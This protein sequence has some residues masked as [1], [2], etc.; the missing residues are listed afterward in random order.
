MS[1]ESRDE[2][3]HEYPKPLD[4]HWKENWYFNFID[5]EAGAWGIN[6]ISLMRLK[7]QGRFSAFHV[8][9]G[10]VLMYS[11]VIDIQD[12]LPDLTDGRLRFEFIEPFSKFRLTFDG[13]RHRVELDYTARFDVFDYAGARRPGGDKALAVNHYEQALFAKG[14]VEKSGKAYQIDCLGHRDHSWGFRNEAK[15]SGWN[16]MAVQFPDKTIN[17]SLVRIG[18]AFMGSGFISNSEGN[19]RINRVTIQDTKFKNKVPVSSVFT[20]HDKQ[21]GTWRLRSEKFSGLYLPM[22]EKGKGVVVHENFSDYTNLETD[23]KG[24]GI[25]EYLINPEI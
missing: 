2:L 6:H 3:V 4:S 17:M 13:P 7:Q 9:D 20:G 24:V 23:E 10:E 11:N 19:T 16:W 14:R 15:V 8:V 12:E 25:D 18:K 21:G 22:Q 1:L 5:R